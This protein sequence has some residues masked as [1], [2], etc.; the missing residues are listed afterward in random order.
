MW[1][2]EVRGRRSGALRTTPVDLLCLGDR[3]YLV[4]PRGYTEWV[5]NVEAGSE[6][7]LRRG[8]RRTTYDAR[9][10]GEADRPAVLAAYLDGFR[11]EVQR[12]FPVAAGSPPAAFTSLAARYPVFELRPRA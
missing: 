5:R 6:V 9:P 1:L 4:A 2:L 11:R 12:Y 3:L 7:A 8:R 10:L